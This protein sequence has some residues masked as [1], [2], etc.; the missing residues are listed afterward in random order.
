MSLSLTL[1]ETL[2]MNVEVVLIMFQTEQV[3]KS[4]G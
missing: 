2:V 3:I 1:S 4:V